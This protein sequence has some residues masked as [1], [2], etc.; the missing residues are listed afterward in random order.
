M[1]AFQ[2]LIVFCALFAT[3]LEPVDEPWG[4]RHAAIADPDGHVVD[5]SS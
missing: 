2:G 4:V 1:A 5:L 3:T